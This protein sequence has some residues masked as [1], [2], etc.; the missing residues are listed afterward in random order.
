[1][2]TNILYFAAIGDG[3]TLNTIA[4][5]NAIDDC[6]AS[7]GG[8]VTIPTGIYKS[9]TI[10]LRSNVEL[11]LEMGAELLASDNLDDYNDLD[12]YEQNT[13]V[14]ADEGCVGKHLI[15]AYE[16][17]NSAITG[18]GR[19][20]GNCHAFVDP[21]Y[22]ETILANWGWK[23]GIAVLKDEEKM[24]LGQLINFVECKNIKVQNITIVDSPCWSLLFHGC[25]FVQVNS[26]RVNNPAWMLNSDGIDID[27]S[28]YVTVSDCIILTGDDAITLRACEHIVKTNCNF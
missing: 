17:E 25:K 19:I 13:R 26:I 15:I 8:R 5:Q 14:V 9:G 18:L 4:I 12:A 23:R 2:N 7:G 20:N 10:W 11:H 21:F 22:G 28:R 16:I 24:R 3:K 6:A 27:A 1:M